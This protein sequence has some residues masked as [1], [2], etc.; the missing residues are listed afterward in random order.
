[1]GYWIRDLGYEMRN[2]ISHISYLTSDILFGFDNT[3]HLKHS[4]CRFGCVGEGRVARQTG[5]N[6]I[7]AQHVH[8]RH[9]VAGCRDAFGIKLFQLLEM[10]E[11]LRKLFARAFAFGIGKFEAREQRDIID[12]LSG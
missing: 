11:D 1:M 12:F 2:P 3:R 8:D 5:A 7:E 10:I 4:A 6:F 9:D